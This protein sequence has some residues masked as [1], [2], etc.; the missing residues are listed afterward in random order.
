MYKGGAGSGNFGH[1]GRPG[2]VG[3][4]VGS[5]DGL[6]AL[7][8][9]RTGTTPAVRPNPNM[10]EAELM[11]RI[12]G[13]Y[14]QTE[15]PPE[16]TEPPAERLESMKQS[17]LTPSDIKGHVDVYKSP[18][19]VVV[20]FQG[21]TK[22]R[23]TFGPESGSMYNPHPQTTSLNF[24]DEDK[25]RVID[26][27]D[28]LKAKFGQPTGINVIDNDTMRDLAGVPPWGSTPFGASRLGGVGRDGTPV[29]MM[30]NSNVLSHN[31]DFEDAAKTGAFMP[32]SQTTDPLVYTITHETGHM[33]DS[34]A[35]GMTSDRMDSPRATVR[36][37]SEIPAGSEYGRQSQTDTSPQG[38]LAESFAESF[39]E[40]VLTNGQTSDKLS[41]ALAKSEGWDKKI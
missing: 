32:S 22:S 12:N 15:K 27:A 41:Q 28:D 11:A 24:S 1:S 31:D 36:A 4:S 35:V 39:A 29:P 7:T 2:A 26:A 34:A 17:R 5:G 10:S 23:I 19:G 13:T 6:H 33:V 21:Q 14:G 3:G 38:T 40:Y 37:L 8:A 25:L 18:H 20:R 16:K 30:L 9:T